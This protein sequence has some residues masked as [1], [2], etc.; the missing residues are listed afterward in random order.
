MTPQATR[1]LKNTKT[2]LL[3]TLMYDIHNVIIYNKHAILAARNPHPM[4]YPPDTVTHSRTD[5]VSADTPFA[6][7][8][9]SSVES[10]CKRLMRHW[11]ERV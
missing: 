6:V 5:Y 11:V 4:D 7:V 3:N 8:A 9:Y 1:R 2:R 10:V